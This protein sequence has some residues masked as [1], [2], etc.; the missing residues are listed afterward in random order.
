MPMLN[1][2]RRRL[3]TESVE[4]QMNCES[5]ETFVSDSR[6]GMRPINVIEN[7]FGVAL[8]RESRRPQPLSTVGRP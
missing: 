3:G 8:L 1:D 5:D 4:E 6:N 7:K 2:L